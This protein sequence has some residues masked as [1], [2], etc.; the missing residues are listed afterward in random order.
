MG[1]VTE[2]GSEGQGNNVGTEAIGI[3]EALNLIE[4]GVPVLPGMCLEEAVGAA[5]LAYRYYRRKGRQ[6]D[7]RSSF[8][9]YMRLSQL[10]SK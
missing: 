9:Q 7:A 2:I 1:K 5:F 4:A 8:A 6:E 10:L 3:V